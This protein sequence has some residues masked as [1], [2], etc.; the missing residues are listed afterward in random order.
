MEYCMIRMNKVT[1]EY[2]KHENC[3]RA[4]SEIDFK[5]NRG[6]FV[7]ITGSSGS[8]KTT[9]LNILGC[10]DRPTSG[11]YMI[12]GRETASLSSSEQ[13]KIRNQTFGFVMQN[14]ALIDHFSVYKNVELP[15]KYA[16]KI[17]SRETRIS[18]LLKALNIEDKKNQITNSLSGGQKQRVAI[19]RA[20]VNDAEIIL[21]DEPTGALDTKN[22]IQVMEILSGLHRQ[23][24]TIIMVT[25]NPELLGYCSRTVKIEDGK[26]IS[27]K[28][29]DKNL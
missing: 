1:K 4:L 5:V 2:G 13:A 9:L 27:D 19:A 20:L 12:N 28:I 22:G 21:A 6:E 26:I 11:S 23:G 29:S 16:R 7:A 10:M 24:K 15:L 18:E 25:H 17:K 14:Y 8:G 3:I